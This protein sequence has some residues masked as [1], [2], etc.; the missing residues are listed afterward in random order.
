M[1]WGFE[2]LFDLYFYP[3]LLKS[4]ENIYSYNKKWHVSL[5]N[6][7]KVMDKTKNGKGFLS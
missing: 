3:L 6:L 5:H 7:G 1:S 4:T 2:T